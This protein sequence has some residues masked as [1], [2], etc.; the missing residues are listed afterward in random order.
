MRSIRLYLLLGLM[1]GVALANFLAA[2]QGYQAGIRQTEALLDEQLGAYTELLSRLPI[3]SADSLLVDELPHAIAYQLGTVDGVLLRSSHLAPP[4]SLFMHEAGYFETNFSGHRWRVLV[5]ELTRQSGSLRI[6]VATTVDERQRIAE[7]IVTAAIWPIVAV[8]PLLAILVWWLLGRGLRPLYRLASVLESRRADDLGKL[9]I[10]ETP[11]EIRPLL[12]SANHLLRRVANALARERHLTADAAHEL[13]TPVSA[14]KLHAYNLSQELGDEHSGVSHLKQGLDRLAHLTE[15]LLQLHKASSERSAKRFETVDLYDLAQQSIARQFAN[16]ERKQ[17][18]VTLVGEAVSLEGDALSLERLIDNLL[19]N[20][21]KY[22]PVGGVIQ[23]EVASTIES[24]CLSVS[25]NGPGVS[26]DERERIFE[27]F[28]RA[29]GDAHDSGESGC[30]LG[31]A[32][33]QK[34]AVLHAASVTAE[35]STF[36]SGLCVRV[37]FHTGLGEGDVNEYH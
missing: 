8:L 7:G 10:G 30:G 35:N 20:A 34:V 23:L 14:L 22:T 2:L 31:L 26:P 37:C 15:Q 32:I 4:E 24:A 25:D 29:G 13:R 33:V 28:Y 9:T 5:R 27:R 12:D 21:N 19:V 18:E 36:A 16:I 17:Q 1:A 3:D 6:L 11:S